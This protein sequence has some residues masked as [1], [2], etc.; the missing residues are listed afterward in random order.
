MTA[1]A[2]Q[3]L[4]TLSRNMQENDLCNTTSE[5]LGVLDGAVW[6]PIKF[7]L[8]VWPIVY[9]KIV[10]IYGQI[11]T[12]SRIE[13][14]LSTIMKYPDMHRL[15]RRGWDFMK[16]TPDCPGVV[17]FF[18]PAGQLLSARAELS[19]RRLMMEIS[20]NHTHRLRDGL[21]TFAFLGYASV[22]EAEEHVAW[23]NENCNPI[24]QA[25]A[26]QGKLF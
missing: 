17:L 16:Y 10:E 12:K 19:M 24:A 22:E 1:A 13:V 25:A 21:S 23:L 5:E 4:A 20:A 11:S 7:S 15:T 2:S 3:A 14:I 9:E 8:S 26:S 18:N 6:S